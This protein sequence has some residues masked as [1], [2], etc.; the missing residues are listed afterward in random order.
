MLLIIPIT[1]RRTYHFSF[2]RNCIVP[3]SIKFYFRNIAVTTCRPIV[4]QIA[5]HFRSI[6]IN[7]ILKPYR[8]FFNYKQCVF[9]TEFRIITTFKDSTHH[10]IDKRL[11]KQVEL[12]KNSHLFHLL[13]ITEVSKV[14]QFFVNPE[15]NTYWHQFPITINGQAKDSVSINILETYLS[16]LTLT[17]S[18]RHPLHVRRKTQINNLISLWTDKKA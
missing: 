1:T 3:L 12:M 11:Y 5:I 8:L 6:D 4:T 18:Y 7:H 17:D 10:T 16:I 2:Q 15:R 13:P 9:R 14:F